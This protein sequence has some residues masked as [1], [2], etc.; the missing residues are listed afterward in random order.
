MWAFTCRGNIRSWETSMLKSRFSLRVAEM[1]DQAQHIRLET[2]VSTWP[3]SVYASCV[4]HR[5]LIWS[6]SLPPYLPCREAATSTEAYWCGTGLLLSQAL[7]QPI[8]C[9]VQNIFGH[10]QCMVVAI[11]I[12]GVSSMLCATAQNMVWLIAARVASLAC[13][14]CWV[15]RALTSV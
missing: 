10:K 2:S 4:S 7:A 13:T 11:A 5:R 8:Y 15:C 9:V 1:S 3:L 14:V 12:F 6:S